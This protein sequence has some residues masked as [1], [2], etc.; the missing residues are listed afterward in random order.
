[1]GAPPY[2]QALAMIKHKAKTIMNQN[3]QRSKVF[4]ISKGRVLMPTP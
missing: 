2:A 1:L 4:E 3:M